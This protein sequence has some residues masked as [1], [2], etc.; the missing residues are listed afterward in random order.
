MFGNDGYDEYEIL[1]SLEYDIFNIVSSF[2]WRN[3]LLSLEISSI[4]P[5]V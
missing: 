4:F 5:V 3:M 2:R 1:S